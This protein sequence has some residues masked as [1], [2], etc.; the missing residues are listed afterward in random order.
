MKFLINIF[1]NMPRK[2]PVFSAHEKLAGNTGVMSVLQSADTEFVIK[3]SRVFVPNCCLK[4]AKN[5][6]YKP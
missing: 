6:P 5:M 1:Y 3:I 2:S 4:T